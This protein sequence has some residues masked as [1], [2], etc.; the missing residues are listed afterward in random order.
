VLGKILNTQLF[1]LQWKLWNIYFINQQ[2]SKKFFI[3]SF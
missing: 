3:A 2:F 1:D